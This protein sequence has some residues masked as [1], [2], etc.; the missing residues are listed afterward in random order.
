VRVP[1][2]NFFQDN[3]PSSERQSGDDEGM[4][5]PADVLSSGFLRTPSR[6]FVT[7]DDVIEHIGGF[8]KY[9]RRLFAILS[10]T[11]L[12]NGCLNLQQVVV[13]RA[14]SCFVGGAQNEQGACTDCANGKFT[15]QFVGQPT[16][17]ATFELVCSDAVY[18]GWLGSVFFLGFGFGSYFGGIL[19]D[20]IGRRRSI[21]LVNALSIVG[22]LSVLAWSYSVYLLM[23][24]VAGAAC[25][26]GI[27]INF[28]LMM[29][30]TGVKYRGTIGGLGM[31]GMWA[32]GGVTMGM[33][34]AAVHASFA[35]GGVMLHEWQAVSM[36]PAF[37]CLLQAFLVM[38]LPESPRWLAIRGNTE[39][40]RRIL[41]KAAAVNGTR[42]PAAALR[43]HDIERAASSLSAAGGPLPQ[44]RDSDLQDIG[45]VASSGHHANGDA[46]HC[47]EQRGEQGG[48]RHPDLAKAA[49]A[50]GVASPSADAGVGSGGRG[51]LVGR[52]QAA[53]ASG[54]C[55]EC[56]GI[57]ALFSEKVVLGVPLW[58]TTLI[59][60][61]CWFTA[62]FTYY[63][64]ALNTGNLAGDFYLNFCV[65]MFVDI[66]ALVLSI[67]MFDRLGRQ[68]TL[69]LT[70]I[71]GGISCVGCTLFSVD[72]ACEEQGP[73]CFNLMS[74]S[75]LAFC[76]KFMLCITF[77]GVFLYA[78]EVFP[79]AIRTQG[80]G[81]SSVAAR[82][83]GILA[84]LVVVVLGQGSRDAP[85]Y[86]FGLVSL[87]A[88]VCSIRLP[89]TLNQ[90]LAD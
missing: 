89:E 56:T 65:N 54:G 29:E 18:R 36:L 7:V 72:A 4:S 41:A 80:M 23:R 39:E 67:P 47:G 70:L 81:L 20:Q 74:R 84:P 30:F 11:F 8:G 52:L 28:V 6:E 33:Y 44:P 12:V 49:E 27:I 61:L 9:Q 85:M 43:P 35:D 86:V 90:F 64:L 25:G 71:L 73:A 15:G 40:A 13:E 55:L 53:A 69:S 38:F 51:G 46:A 68:R 5:C 82:L 3:Q 14:P 10:F 62:S 63:G 17:A 26:S 22:S 50:A 59:N 31:N 57:K 75:W 24:F 76:G 2:P 32:M 66:P 78:S 60:L 88:G 21:F 42:M 45:R 87:A 34:G 1:R 79:T 83:G 58:Q 37:L 48:E 19:S 77:S 16:V